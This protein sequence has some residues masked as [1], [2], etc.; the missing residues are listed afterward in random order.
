MLGGSGGGDSDAPDD[1]QTDPDDIPPPQGPGEIEELIGTWRP[2]DLSG[3]GDGDDDPI[4]IEGR[5]GDD[6]LHGYDGDEL[7]GGAGSD[8]F[9]VVVGQSDAAPVLIE[10]LNFSLSDDQTTPDQILFTTADGTAVPLLG[11]VEAGIEIVDEEDGSGASIL[12]DGATVAKVANTTADQL[13][14]QSMWIGNFSNDINSGSGDDYLVGD[15]YLNPNDHLNGGKG[16]DTLIGGNGT[17]ILH[18][19]EGDDFIDATDPLAPSANFDLVVGGEG[20]DTM[21]GDDGD[22]L[23]GTFDLEG[24]VV[25]VDTSGNDQ[26]EVLMSD[27]PDA[28]PVVIVG[29]SYGEGTNL[30]ET[31]FLLHPDGTVVSQEELDENLVVET[32]VDGVAHSLI[33]DGVEVAVVFDAIWLFD[34]YGVS[35]ANNPE[36]AAELAEELGLAD[37]L[38]VID[39][40]LTGAE[41]SGHFVSDSL[42]GGNIIYVANT[43]QGDPVDN[44]KS[45]LDILEIDHVRFPAGQ[46]DHRFFEGD[47]EEW[48]NVVV[49]EPNEFGEMDLRP[50]LK[51]LL[52]WAQDPN[53][54]GEFSDAKS[55]TLVLPTQ[56]Y[57]VEQYVAFAPEIEQFAAKLVQDYGDVVE[58]LEIGNEYW[59]MGETVYATKANIAIDSLLKGFASAGVDAED[60]PDILVQMGSPNVGSEFNSAVDD[61][62]FLDRNRDANLQIINTLN[63]QSKEAI[64]GVVEHYYFNDKDP[65]FD[66]DSSEVNF[67]N[68]DLEIWNEAFDK[69]L[70]L[71]ITEW[72]VKNSNLEQNGLVYTGAFSE[73][74]SRLIQL[75]VNLAH[76]WAVQHNTAT[77]LAGDRYHEPIVNEAGR[78]V[79]TVRGAM[80]DIT[81][82]IL[83]GAELL[84]LSMDGY[85]GRVE[86]H[87]YQTDDRMVFQISSRVAE[88][89]HL[90]TD[91]SAIV[92]EFASVQTVKVS[93]DTSSSDG[94]HYESGVGMVEAPY[95]IV[96]GQQFYYGEHDVRAVVE[97]G[98]CTSNVFDR[99]YKPFE[100]YQVVFYLDPDTAP[101]PLANPLDGL[102][103]E[104]TEGRDAFE[105]GLGDDTISGFGGSDFLDGLGGNDNIRGGDG[106]DTIVGCLG[107]DVLL[108]EEGNDII[109][110][111]EGN[112]RLRGHE[113]NDT[114]SG[115]IGNDT[116]NGGQDDDLIRGGAGKDLATGFTGADRFAFYEG[117]ISI[118]DEISDFTIGEDVIQIDIPGIS[119]IDDLD[120]RL[121]EE[122]G[123]IFVQLGAEGTIFLNGVVNILDIAAPTNFVFGTNLSAVT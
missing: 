81:N 49:M 18:G 32:R 54:D 117:D 123:G 68:K 93:M 100:T 112:D 16:N 5:D 19:E 99:T 114:L 24:G 85:D 34:R 92:P 61:R 116:M 21:R 69:D 120:F 87:G 96:D 74:I 58:A 103:F 111:K 62:D 70:K 20:H 76:I 1:D 38:D 65:V 122:A 43:D 3:Y 95:V 119:S 86:I 13:N 7:V 22:Y 108:G 2:D 39:I 66:H 4:R 113:G 33:Y 31:L 37:A 73:E 83:P 84:E 110:G 55:V 115:G 46:G 98:E 53:G 41:G 80:F 36:A 10:D 60:Q 12:F 79:S 56:A 52:D 47:G 27:H 50:E 82:D 101:P 40:A 48:L 17:D 29:Q 64:D 78:L 15:Q 72:N 90:I 26:F 91:F 14:G 109:D 75:D 71:S 35:S 23:Y 121:D 88:E 104:G 107:D 6:T 118:G 67:I 25:V 42:F 63:D 102:V 94:V 89:V 51:V 45:S 77:D 30:G 105:G 106:E 11:V 97:E 59:A 57:S 28:D 8:V 9:T 44:L